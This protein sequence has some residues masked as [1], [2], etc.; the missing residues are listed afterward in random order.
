MCIRD[1][2]YR[3]LDMKFET[4]DMD[5][6]QPVRTANYTVSEDFTR[7]TEFKN[8]TGQDVPG[9]TTIMKE[10]SHAL[11]LIH[12]LFTGTFD[13]YKPTGKMSFKASSFT[14]AGEGLLRQQVAQLAEKLR[15][16]GLMEPERKR[17]CL[18]YTS[19]CV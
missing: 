19:R 4:L 8:M 3:T 17:R 18:L 6:F 2:P 11:S 9:K 13:L 1:R 15:R 16:E 10:Y 7:I 12:I 5:Q 14:L